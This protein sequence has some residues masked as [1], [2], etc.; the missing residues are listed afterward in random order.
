MEIEREGKPQTV[1]VA[2]QGVADKVQF[3]LW[4]ES[5]ARLETRVMLA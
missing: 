5:L 1:P 2:R 4:A 3:P